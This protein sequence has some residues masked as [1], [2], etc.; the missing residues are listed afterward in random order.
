M[1]EAASESLTWAGLLSWAA[2]NG[3]T[4]ET[5]LEDEDGNPILDLSFERAAEPDPE[6][7]EDKGSDALLILQKTY[8]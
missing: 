8:G 4:P 1:S 5:K 7:P 3:V 6:D 2:A